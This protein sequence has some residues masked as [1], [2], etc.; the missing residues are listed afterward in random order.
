[1]SSRW[2]CLNT[3]TG[4]LADFP[5]NRTVVKARQTLYS[6]L[7]FS[8]DGSR[9]YASM[10]SLTDPL[11]NGK[12]LTGNGIVVYRFAD[13]KI[14]PGATDPSAASAAR[15]GKDDAPDRR[16]DRA[17]RACRTRRQ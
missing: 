11:G 9:I 7:A 2:R 5:D 15:S 12:D 4:A 13:G 1:M 3:Q 17:T 6:G 16:T 10:A 14:T 8:R